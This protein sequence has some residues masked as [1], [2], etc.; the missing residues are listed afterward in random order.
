MG[1]VPY[2]SDEAKRRAREAVRAMD[3]Y[4]I[5]DDAL[6]VV[7]EEAVTKGAE[8]EGEGEGGEEEAADPE[9]VSQGGYVE[10]ET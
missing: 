2:V 1:S 9:G 8:K 10:E 3:R 4:P 6:M 7:A 5:A